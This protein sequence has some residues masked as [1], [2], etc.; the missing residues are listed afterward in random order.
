[1]LFLVFLGILQ[2]VFFQ[3]VLS[4]GKEKITFSA[5]YFQ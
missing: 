3:D 1:V 5:F 4:L 2:L